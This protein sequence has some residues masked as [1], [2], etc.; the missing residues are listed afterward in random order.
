MPLRKPKI[1]Q[2]IRLTDGFVK[3]ENGAS[4]P[5]N[6]LVPLTCW[7]LIEH[8]NG[9]TWVEGMD[10]GPDGVT[11]AQDTE[12]FVGYIDASQITGA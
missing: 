2:I 5:R 7:A 1:M 4:E 10:I 8:E 12:N 6:K 3:Y 9:D 11:L